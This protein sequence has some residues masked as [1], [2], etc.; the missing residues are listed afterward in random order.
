M[1]ALADFLNHGILP[2]T[3]RSQQLNELHA[4]WRSTIE[5]SSLRMGLLV[6][7]AGSGKSSLIETLAPMVTADGGVMIH[8]KLYPDAALSLAPLMAHVLTR[9][10][11]APGILRQAP[12]TSLGGVAGALRRLTRLRPT[13][14]VIED[15]HLLANESLGELSRLLHALADEPLTVLCPA[16]PFDSTIQGALERYTV[17]EWHLGGLDQ[18][19]V[20]QLWVELF[21][22]RPD[23]S[24]FKAL[25]TATLGNP[26]A[27]RSALRGA[28][29]SG[30]ITCEHTTNRWHLAVSHRQFEQVLERSVRLLSEGMAAHLTDEERRI[31]EQFACLG[32]LFPQE[33]I[34][35][36]APKKE[37]IVERLVFKG[38]LIVSE[39]ASRPLAGISKSSP[40][41]FTHTLLHRRF[42]ESATTDATALVRVIASGVPLYSVLP[43]QLIAEGADIRIDAECEVIAHAVN[44]VMAIIPGLNITTDWRLNV[45]LWHAANRIVQLRS[46]CW[47]QEQHA[48]QELAMLDARII[49]EIRNQHTDEYYN[50]AMQMLELSFKAE[51][52]FFVTHRMRAYGNLH[53][54][55][56]RRMPERCRQ[57]WNDV[58]NLLEQHPYLRYTNAYIRYIGRVLNM[59]GVVASELP[60]IAE[61]RAEELINCNNKNPEFSEAIRFYILPELLIMFDS[62]EKFDRR[63]QF[64]EELE[65]GPR[66]S[67]Y[68]FVVK[69]IAIRLH[70]G[71][72]YELSQ[73]MDEFI[74]RLGEIGEF[75]ALCYAQ[76]VQIFLEAI[77]GEHPEQVEPALE[78]MLTTATPWNR[79]ALHENITQYIVAVGLL[80]GNISWAEKIYRQVG[81]DYPVLDLSE[82]IILRT[83][84]TLSGEQYAATEVSDP[85]HEL[86]SLFHAIKGDAIPQERILATIRGVTDSEPY[87]LFELITFR[88]TVD[89]LQWLDG[90]GRYPGILQELAPELNAA[91]NGWLEWLATQ[92][93]W[94]IITPL[95]DRYDHYLTAKERKQWLG[96]IATLRQEYQPHRTLRGGSGRIRVSMIGTIK[97]ERPEI[98][99]QRLRG[100][101]VSKFL[102]M[103]VADQMLDPPLSFREMCRLI[104]GGEFDPERERKALNDAVYRLREVLGHDAV[105]TEREVS[106]LNSDLVE[107]DLLN[108]HRL[109]K[110]AT[111]AIR[112]GALARA[113]KATMATLDIADGEVPFPGLY[114]VF[115]E[116]AR[117]EF[118]VRVRHTLITLAEKLLEEGDTTGAEQLLRRGFTTMPEDED[119]MER[120]C[121]VLE[122]MGRYT[123]A[124][125]VRM[126]ASQAED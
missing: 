116:A 83:Q 89:G 5:S 11:T 97:V 73:L 103:L 35:L 34:A 94:Q 76:V 78:K 43:F 13:L 110:E 9:P 105:I 65:N 91:L 101:R 70:A 98:P 120:L 102:G 93:L 100:P 88:S 29:K 28:L 19:E 63:V 17:H 79:A 10:G 1:H 48:M 41:S 33:A 2:F 54:S 71:R 96:T 24:I 50:L 4:F 22:T 40:L 44:R 95:L 23:D 51:T 74:L 123:E 18:K 77:L 126:R 25:Y 124:V 38:I 115:F 47:D 45:P 59:S 30:A 121:Q 67:P 37:E 112:E 109:L 108:A 122:R 58:E 6:G 117:T 72:L 82:M 52:E 42:V 64:L 62:K 106:R 3:G 16:R 104:S 84:G 39:T 61:I 107:V 81:S 32:E 21:G 55:Y 49:T 119:I 53:L 12:E 26:L 46:D 80:R 66:A 113:L 7:E 60:R 27:L 86:V 56:F 14:L 90:H 85:E 20:G 69:K 99:A 57:L 31:A 92:G 68:H 75:L 118:E 111:M 15:I 114:D 87:D 36:L 8:V 125:R